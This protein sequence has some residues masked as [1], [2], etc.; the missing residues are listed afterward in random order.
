MPATP[1][2][3]ARWTRDN[4]GHGFIDSNGNVV[5]FNVPELVTDEEAEMN[6]PR[7]AY[8]HFTISPGGHVNTHL[9]GRLTMT[10]FYHLFEQAHPGVIPH[11]TKTATYK[12]PECH[13]PMVAYTIGGGW[14]AQ[15][16]QCP[17]CHYVTDE[18]DAQEH[19]RSNSVV[20]AEWQRDPLQEAYE[21]PSGLAWGDP[22][23]SR[24]AGVPEEM[25]DDDTTGGHLDGNGYNWPSYQLCRVCRGEGAYAND[26]T[27]YPPRTQS[28][29]PDGTPGHCHNNNCPTYDWHAHGYTN[30]KPQWALDRD[31]DPLKAQW[32]DS[33]SHSGNEDPLW[34]DFWRGSRRQ[35]VSVPAPEEW[36]Q[37]RYQHPEYPKTL[38]HGTTIDR[39]PNIMRRGLLPWDQVGTRYEQGKSFLTPRPGHVYL[40]EDEDI[41]KSHS[42]MHSRSAEDRAILHIDPRFLRAENINPDED[43]WFHNTPG[44]RYNEDTP[45]YQS[46]NAL[47]TVYNN[48]GG[49]WGFGVGTL[50]E[51]A[52][53]IGLGDDPMHTRMGIESE[54]TI[55]HRGPI[56]PEAITPYTLQ[57][58]HPNG[59][60]KWLP[61][62]GEAH[63]SNHGPSDSWWEPFLPSTDALGPKRG[64]PKC[65]TPMDLSMSDD[66]YG[67][68]CPKCH[69]ALNGDGDEV[70]NYPQHQL[71][72]E[73]RLRKVDD[74]DLGPVRQGAQE[75]KCQTPGAIYDTHIND[76][77]VSVKV[78]LPLDLSEDEAEL[79][80]A[81]LHNAVE[82]VLAPHSKK[83]AWE[84]VRMGPS[85]HDVEPK[86]EEC[87]NCHW[88]GIHHG[89]C[90]QCGYE[91]ISDE[92][93]WDWANDG[94]PLP[95]PHFAND[96]WSP[97]PVHEE[98]PLALELY[99][100]LKGQ[101]REGDPAD[102]RSLDETS[103]PT[104]DPLPGAYS[105]TWHE[106]PPEDAVP[107]WTDLRAGTL[108]ARR[109]EPSERLAGP[110][111]DTP[112]PMEPMTA[113]PVTTFT[114]QNQVQHIWAQI[115]LA[116]EHG[117]IERARAL[118]ARLPAG[119][120]P[121][122][123][124]AL[125]DEGWHDE[126]IKLPAEPGTDDAERG[127]GA[128]PD[129]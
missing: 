106:S 80:E 41:A 51:Q 96:G 11:W 54:N 115:G 31:A 2:P 108:P 28:L 37:D 107:P 113:E 25:G 46:W 129:E 3:R 95:P 121:S 82:L 75:T 76:K 94:K 64:C 26:Q 40:A 118:Y 1:H 57:G 120:R 117:D 69:Y 85:F 24:T 109:S 79:L 43:A 10:Q 67:F 90:S 63:F 19:E 39:L 111:L 74:L 27:G 81:N 14:D 59:A 30:G 44:N 102:P 88:C 22:R 15:M 123:F 72:S 29:D 119:Q 20:P 100:W 83:G 71:H 122:H 13:T 87:P 104:P 32:D 62:N 58:W 52:E 101:G 38:Y 4:H 65:N 34:N 36:W 99:H 103:I 91:H 92:D 78:D 128:N 93:T 48:Y 114:P 84:P 16:Y 33:P 9:N 98:A 86:I 89:T 73:P 42:S 70:Y 60:P 61:W 7:D 17:A 47:P 21:R 56:P 45:E 18:A 49:E 68:N 5:T 50:G 77:G 125:G 112:R 66:S 55:A 53:R 126:T 23:N 12:C 116:I 127:E 8:A 6:C 35:V 110:S 105:R 124:A 97:P